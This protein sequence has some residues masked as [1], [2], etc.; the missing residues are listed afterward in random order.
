M[1]T[2][3]APGANLHSETLRDGSTVLLRTIHPEDAQIET[4][5]VERLSE[6]SRYMRFFQPL[7]SLSPRMLARFTQLDY[8]REMAVIATITSGGAE[9]ILGVA[10]YSP[11]SDPTS[12]E[13][14][15]VVAD[16]WQGRGLGRLLMQRLIEA[17]RAAGYQRMTGSVLHNN[18]P[19]HH[20]VRKLGFV[21][22]GMGPDPA[23]AEYVLE[24]G[25]AL[26]AKRP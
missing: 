1:A 19:M 2:H 8:E 23:V 24:L 17:A 18:P 4:E 3:P 26:P 13:F 9:R 20:L 25:A 21:R 15:V 12:C 7:K 16:D 5:F 6:E 11:N 10:R 22:S 14:A